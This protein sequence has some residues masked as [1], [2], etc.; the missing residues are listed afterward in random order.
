MQETTK[1][2]AKSKVGVGDQVNEAEERPHALKKWTFSLKAIF[3]DSSDSSNSS[4]RV[5]RKIWY[6]VPIHPFSPFSKAWE[7]V[8]GC[9]LLYTTTATP[10]IIAFYSEQEGYCQHSSTIQLDMLVDIFFMVE[11]FIQFFT[12]RVFGGRYLD[13]YASVAKNYATNGLAVDVMSAC[14]MSWMEYYL[15]PNVPCDLRTEA[16][17]QNAF[18][19]YLRL[20]RLLRLLRLLKVLKIFNVLRK[21]FHF[22]PNVIRLYKLVFAVCII[23]HLSSCAWWFV[24]IQEGSAVMDKFKLVHNIDRYGSLGSPLGSNYI[25]ALYF[26]M[27]TLCTVGYGDISADEDSER[28][29]MTFIMLLGASVFAIIISNMSTLVVSMRGAEGM[30][31]DRCDAIVTYLRSNA[32]PAKLDKQIGRFY[33]YK[34]GSPSQLSEIYATLQG[35]PTALQSDI[36][37]AIFSPT[38][39]ALSFCDLGDS[40]L[41][42]DLKVFL[43]SNMQIDIFMPGDFISYMNELCDNFHVILHGAAQQFIAAETGQRILVDTLNISNVTGLLELF[44]DVPCMVDTIALGFVETWSMDALVWKQLL[45]EF[46]ALVPSMKHVAERRLLTFSGL[47]EYK[48]DGRWKLKRRNDVW[49]HWQAIVHQYYLLCRAKFSHLNGFQERAASRLGH[50]AMF[51]TTAAQLDFDFSLGEAVAFLKEMKKKR[52]EQ[53]EKALDAYLQAE[54]NKERGGAPGIAAFGEETSSTSQ[55]V[56]AGIFSSSSESVEVAES[57]INLVSSIPV[58]QESTQSLQELLFTLKSYVDWISLKIQESASVELLENQRKRLSA[59]SFIK[60]SAWRLSHGSFNTKSPV[61]SKEHDVI[62]T[63]QSIVNR[64][65]SMLDNVGSK[66]QSMVT[67]CEEIHQRLESMAASQAARSAATDKPLAR[68]SYGPSPPPSTGIITTPLSFEIDRVTKD[69]TMSTPP[70][71]TDSPKIEAELGGYGGISEVSHALVGFSFMG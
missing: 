1:P 3:S 16:E 48:H 32:F 9:L 28:I 14:P 39:N 7:F 51:R 47:L 63:V 35:L 6:R 53:K 70:R 67:I 65:T 13:G 15:V 38:I 22:R 58:Q 62:S 25:L 4:A 34:S 55:V 8:S 31:L 40:S 17:K 23:G 57:N 54:M 2:R 19:R 60:R 52:N 33:A 24:K 56:G 18:I 61:H 20:I 59:R 41:E 43:V 68:S 37:I 11:I 64:E 44:Q 45:E 50:F 30:Y 49:A 10:F 66:L 5:E 46:P 36:K 71:L 27:A 26:Q 21:L 29:L 69:L 12:G 42:I